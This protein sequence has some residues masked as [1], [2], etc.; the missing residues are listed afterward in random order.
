MVHSSALLTE[1][2]HLRLAR[3]VAEDGRPLRWAPE[4]FQVSAP[5]A[6]RWARRPASW[7]GR[8]GQSRLTNGEVERLRRTCRRVGLLAP[9]PKHCNEFPRGL[10]TYN[11]HAATPHSEVNHPIAAYLTSQVGTPRSASLGRSI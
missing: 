6:P 2:G 8:D 4:R 10:R 9:L 11:L 1:A 3:C 7:G 5:T